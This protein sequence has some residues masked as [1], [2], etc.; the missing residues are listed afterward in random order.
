M[1]LVKS[2]YSALELGCGMCSM[3]VVVEGESYQE[4]WE[5]AQGGGYL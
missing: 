5:C 3:C 4:E 2:W 1:V